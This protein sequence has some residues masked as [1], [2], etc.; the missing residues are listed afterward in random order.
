ME[1]QATSFKE[2]IS[3]IQEGILLS[4]NGQKENFENLYQTL[5]LLENK[6]TNV[7]ALSAKEFVNFLR[8]DI[9]KLYFSLS[10]LLREILSMQE[11]DELL[12]L[13]VIKI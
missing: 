11:V 2:I 3:K 6:E 9:G 7:E 5:K 12:R 4:L 13:Q 8:A 1:A 10:S